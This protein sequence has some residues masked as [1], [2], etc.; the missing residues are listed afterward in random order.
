MFG[1]RGL[2]AE[3]WKAVAFHP[4][5]QPFDADVWELY[6]LDQDFAENH[7][8]A[9]RHP[10][11]LA[12]LQALWWQEAE[13]NQ[14]LPLDD[15]F[16][17]RFAENGRRV[18]GGR[19]H[20]V[21]HAGMGHLPTDVAPDVRRR[22]YQIEAEVR[23]GPEGAEGV[24]IAHGDATSGYSLYL[25]GGHL[26]HDLNVGGRHHVLRSSQPVP[27]GHHHLGLR[28]QLGPPKPYT[29][30]IAG[31][32]LLPAFRLATLLVDGQ[33][34]GSLQMDHGLNNFISWSGLD[35]GSDRGSPVSHYEAPFAFTGQLRCVRIQL[36]PLADGPDTD[37]PQAGEAEGHAQMARQ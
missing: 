35:I 10:E 2:W 30:P 20:F 19:T 4:R 21:L 13:R 27:A 1:H 14:V 3:G 29:C 22:N 28:M 16:G 26:V 5:G 36:A 23:I 32:I 15:R 18:Q 25:Q 34:A 24:L 12:Q 37:D 6:H 17:P 9:A 33:E 8:L 11:R 7:N 31:P